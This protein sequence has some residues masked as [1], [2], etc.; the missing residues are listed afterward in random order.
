MTLVVDAGAP[1]PFNGWP[2]PTSNLVL[3]VTELAGSNGTWLPLADG[4]GLFG[5]ADGSAFDSVGIYLFPGLTMPIPLLGVQITCQAV[6][7]DPLAPLGFQL[8]FPLHTL[9][10]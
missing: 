3:G 6:Y 1:T 10:L 4:I 9:G 2:D 5:P 7:L 8:S